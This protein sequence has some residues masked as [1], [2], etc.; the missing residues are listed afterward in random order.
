MK[1]EGAE[2]EVKK[3]NKHRSTPLK[4]EVCYFIEKHSQEKLHKFFEEEA[5]M[6]NE[7]SLIRSTY[8]RKNELQSLIYNTR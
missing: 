1:K 5:T 6:R 7:D 8:E 2:D 3:I 4:P